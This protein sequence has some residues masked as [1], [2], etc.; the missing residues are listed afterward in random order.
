VLGCT[1]YVSPEYTSR[2]VRKG[3][4][5]LIDEKNEVEGCPD[6]SCNRHSPG[7]LW[8]RVTETGRMRPGVEVR[9]SMHR[10]VPENAACTN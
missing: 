7:V 2:H 5:R 9:G 8:R 1:A 10:R 4:E 3:Y 6:T